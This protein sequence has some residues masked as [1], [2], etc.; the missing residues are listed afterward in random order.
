M[1]YNTLWSPEVYWVSFF[2]KQFSGVIKPADQEW[3]SQCLYDSTGQLKQDF[4]QNS[5]HPPSPWTTS[6]PNPH[7][8]F[9]W[10]YMFPWATMKMWSIPLKCTQCNMKMHQSGIYTDVR[11]VIDINSTYYLVGGD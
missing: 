9:R 8:F 2:S 7:S 5:F 11:E 6:P 3:I 1:S 4:S 10:F